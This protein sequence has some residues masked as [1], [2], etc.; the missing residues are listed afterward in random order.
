MNDPAVPQENSRKMAMLLISGAVAFSPVATHGHGVLSR[1][2]RLSPSPAMGFLDG[3]LQE[4]DNFVD[5]AANRRLGNGAK[6]YGKR[7][8]SFYG[9]DDAD[10]K[11]DPNV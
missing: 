10:R 6:F 8:S 1:N 11:R 9:E 5:D 2:V 4:L 7:K 3:F